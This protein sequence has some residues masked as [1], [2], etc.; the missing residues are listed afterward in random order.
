MRLTNRPGKSLLLVVVAGAVIT[1][2]LGVAAGLLVNRRAHA[3]D[4]HH[5]GSKSKSKD[6][7]PEIKTVHSLGEFVV[8]LADTNSLRYAKCSIA[9]G[10]AEQIPEEKL[11]DDEPKLR[12]AVIGVLTRKR[13]DELHRRGGL[14]R[15]KKELQSATADHV[16]GATVV[17]VYLEQFAMQ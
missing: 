16:A 17:E 11:K 6:D 8:N 12:D 5:G 14:Q 4:A 9:L 13:F 2:L 1:L 10:F 7:K 3:A 15:L